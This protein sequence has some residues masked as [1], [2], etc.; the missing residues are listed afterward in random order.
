MKQK[1]SVPV[2]IRF[3]DIDMMAMFTMPNTRSFL[4]WPV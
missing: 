4:I 2:Q 1:H 3:N